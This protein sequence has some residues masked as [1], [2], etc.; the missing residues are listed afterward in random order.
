[1]SKEQ[2][3]GAWLAAKEAERIAI[4][5]RRKT[6]DELLELL[7]FDP[8]HE[9]VAKYMGDNIDG[10]Q[11]AVKITG[12]LNRKIDADKLNEVAAENGLQDHLSTLFRWKPEINMA[13]WK[14]ADAS[15]TGPLLDAITTTPG[16]PSFSITAIAIE[17]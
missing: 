10:T 9:G 17:D 16:R 6:E 2:L 15:I 5:H 11:F 1:M 7:G 8:T 12:R 13:V 14:A 3:M 4:E